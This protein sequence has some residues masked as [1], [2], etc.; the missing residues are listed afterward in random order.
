MFVK[1]KHQDQSLSF[2][3]VAGQACEFIK[4]DWH[5]SSPVNFAKF[6]QNSPPD[7]WLRLIFF[8]FFC[9]EKE[10]QFLQNASGGCFWSFIFLYQISNIDSS[11]IFSLCTTSETDFLCTPSSESLAPEHFSLIRTFAK[12]I[13]L[14]L[15]HLYVFDFQTVTHCSG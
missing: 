10:H 13:R 15:P 9:T 6:L 11:S 5:R 4:K 1:G 3:K 7:D 12:L 14:H 8:F 2:N